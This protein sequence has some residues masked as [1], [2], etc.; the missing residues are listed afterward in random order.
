MNTAV[1]QHDPPPALLGP[2]G[3]TPG[4]TMSYQ[5][6][7]AHATLSCEV[8][9]D[10]PSGQTLDTAR[11]LMLM[12][13]LE[14]LYAAFDKTTDPTYGALNVLVGEEALQS[15]NPSYVKKKRTPDAELLIRVL[16]TMVVNHFRRLLPPGLADSYATS[17]NPTIAGLLNSAAEPTVNDIYSGIKKAFCAPTDEL[18]AAFDAEIAKPLDD[19]NPQA[20]LASVRHRSLFYNRRASIAK[21]PVTN[22]EQLRKALHEI[23]L[24][25]SFE[26]FT[27]HLVGLSDEKRPTTLAA[28]MD[29]FV[30]HIDKDERTRD[31]MTAKGLGQHHGYAAASTTRSRSP[32]DVGARRTASR[33]GSPSPS[34]TGAAA[35]HQQSPTTA[36]GG[37]TAAAGGH[38]GAEDERATFI[39]GL[40][41]NTY[42][43]FNIAKNKKFCVNCHRD[44]HV[45]LECHGLHKQLKADGWTAP[46]KA[47]RPATPPPDKTGRGGGGRSR[48][49]NG[50][51]P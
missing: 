22:D 46:V 5:T 10:M 49:N 11:A 34:T 2:V 1:E 42:E 45:V 47:P 4:G 37:A 28:L 15:S 31:R 26:F 3:S 30:S 33:S 32:G 50:K 7:Y 18:L 13:K 12:A 40:K 20:F 39:K 8:F 44:G 16:D 29:A 24:N 19:T 51:S 21:A 27:T 9:K 43:L 36:T 14:A 23:R 41:V 6:A 17:V 25:P 38:G 35:R 48:R